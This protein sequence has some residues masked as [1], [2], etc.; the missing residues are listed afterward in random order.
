MTEYRFLWVYLQLEI[1]WS[2][3]FTDAEIRL[4]L[5]QLPKDL[6]E[7]YNCCIQR[8][9]SQDNDGRALKVLKWVSF[10]SRPLHI[11]EPKE[12]VAFELSDAAWDAEKVPREEFV[13]GC[14]ANLVVLDPADHCVRF[15]HSSV[16]IYL[17]KH[18]EAFA[19]AYP[20]S[21]EQG[22]LQCGEFCVA[23]LSFSDFNLSLAK[24]GREITS[25]VV[26]NP[27]AL[28]GEAFTSPLRHF[29]RTPKKRNATTV[30]FQ[31]IRTPSTPDRNR[32]KFLEYAVKNWLPQTKWITRFSPMWDK[33]E[34]LATNFNETWNFHPLD[35]GGRSI[36]SHFTQSPWMVCQ[37][38]AYASSHR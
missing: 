29:F 34:Q 33:F 5:S 24:N 19:S 20:I 4:A 6:E 1:L 8:I 3:C 17:E 2:T 11:E 37:G 7:T 31:S 27:A 25:S 21:E 30:K 38:T 28:A 16:K 15:A 32:F 10:A 9:I 13:I 22:P 18:R 35:L 14:C 26:P 23:Y 36:L 12:A